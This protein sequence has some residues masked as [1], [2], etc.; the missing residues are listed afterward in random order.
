M[1]SIRSI[2]VALGVLL[3]LAI[4]GL[5]NDPAHRPGDLRDQE[6]KRRILKKITGL[7]RD[8][9]VYKEQAQ[10]YAREWTRMCRSGAYAAITD[11]EEFAKRITADLQAITRDKHV[12]LR[13]IKPSDV[14]E[15]ALSPLHHPVRFH[16]L[17]RKENTGFRKLEWINGHIGYLDLIRF[18]AIDQARDKVEGAMRFLEN[19]DAI[20]IDIRDNGGGS[21][22]YLSSFFLPHPTQLT[23][24]YY[25]END[26]LEECWTTGAMNGKPLTEVPLFV[27]IGPNTFS[28]AEIFAYDLQ[29][30]KR[31][32]LI[33]QPTKGGAHS[34]DLFK[35]DEQF[36]INISTSYAIN[37]VTHGNWEGTG[38]IPDVPA[39]A[40]RVL[41]TAV[42]LAEKAGMEYAKTREQKLKQAVDGMQAQL[43]LAENGFREHDLLAAKSA[44]DSMFRIGGEAGLIDY[45]FVCVLAYHYQAY[46]GKVEPIHLAILEKSA[47]LFPN[48]FM[49]QRVLAEAYRDLGNKEQALLHYEKA[50]ALDP[51]NP[52]IRKKLAEIAKGR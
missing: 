9:Y 37:P 17:A 1:K 12:S 34:I 5:G 2:A 15:Q 36:E 29:A 28:A 14:G 25:R 6:Y 38:V 16:R 21:G 52:S 30:R 48:S 18:N 11:A 26:Y 43:D 19:A 51:G 32:V 31:A 42:E 24:W 4:N 35:I 33:G 7:I 50:L 47:E 44:L 20:I 40:D 49:A 27:L 3:A 22:D 13:V 39:P 46:S 23:G 8:K 10:G 45:F 41:E